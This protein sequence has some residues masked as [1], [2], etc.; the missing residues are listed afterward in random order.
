VASPANGDEIV[1]LPAAGTGA[2]AELPG[3]GTV[4]EAMVL[5]RNFLA[6]RRRLEPPEERS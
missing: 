2:P 4:V 1:V 6:N 3:A 5:H